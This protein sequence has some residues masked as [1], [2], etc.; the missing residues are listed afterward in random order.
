VLRRVDYKP[1]DFGTNRF[2]STYHR[3]EIAFKPG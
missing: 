3:F 1:R 2:D